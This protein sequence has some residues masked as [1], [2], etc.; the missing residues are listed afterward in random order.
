M[1]STAM[2]FRELRDQK[3]YLKNELKRVEN[4]LTICEE[5]LV[6][7]MI[8]AGQTS[9]RFDGVGLVS[10]SNKLQAKIADREKF[11][12]WLRDTGRGDMIKEDVHY[13]TLQAF[14]NELEGVE[15]AEAHQRGLDYSERATVSLRK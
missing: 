6:N 11:F 8:E 14:A 3:E 10:I 15:L 1:K 13:M 12:V 4:E 2:E 9:A 5:R 7:E